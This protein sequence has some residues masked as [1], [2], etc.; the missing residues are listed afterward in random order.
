M[1]SLIRPPS[2]RRTPVGKV[3]LMLMV[4][5]FD[6]CKVG[7]EKKRQEVFDLL[8]GLED[9]FPEDVKTERD[10]WRKETDA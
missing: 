10:Y 4:K 1:S 3:W 8:V 9:E 6:A 7:N 5:H 2:A